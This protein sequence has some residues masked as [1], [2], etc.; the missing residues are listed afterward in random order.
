VTVIAVIAIAAAV[1]AAG[2]FLRWA[3][4]PVLLAYEIGRK[5]ERIKARQAALDGTGPAHHGG[6]QPAARQPDNER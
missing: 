6:P 3:A 2:L 4:A 5:V 1:I